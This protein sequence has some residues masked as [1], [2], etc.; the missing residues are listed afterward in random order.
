M[1]WPVS[2]TTGRGADRCYLAWD[3]GVELPPGVPAASWA[4]RS[5]T[6][7]LS[8]SLRRSFAADGWLES[9]STSAGA[10]V[11]A[12]WGRPR[13]S[14][15]SGPRL[16]PQCRRSAGRRPDRYALMSA[17]TCQSETECSS[18]GAG[19][20]SS[21]WVLEPVPHPSRAVL[22]TGGVVRSL[23]V[24][25]A[26]APSRF[27]FFPPPRKRSGGRCRVPPTGSP[28]GLRRAGPSAAAARDFPVPPARARPLWW[29]RG[30]TGPALVA[31]WSSVAPLHFGKIKSGLGLRPPEQGTPRPRPRR[32]LGGSECLRPDR[33][34][35]C[36]EIDTPWRL[37][38]P[39]QKYPGPRGS[40]PCAP[41]RRAPPPRGVRQAGTPPAGPNGARGP[42]AAQPVVPGRGK[43]AP[44]ACAPGGD[45]ARP[46]QTGRPSPPRAGGGGMTV[47]SWAQLPVHVPRPFFQAVLALRPDALSRRQ[48]AR[49]AMRPDPGLEKWP[50]SSGRSRRCAQTCPTPGGRASLVPWAGPGGRCMLAPRPAGT[51]IA[52]PATW[53]AMAMP[54]PHCRPALAH[55]RCRRGRPRAARIASA[56]GNCVLYLFRSPTTAHRRCAGPAALLHLVGKPSMFLRPRRVRGKVQASHGVPCPSMAAA[57][58]AVANSPVRPAMSSTGMPE[59]RQPPG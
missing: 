36:T 57:P 9:S 42:P 23:L 49:S 54:P 10:C 7:V 24:T 8:I 51:P 18:C 11:T 58:P 29:R 14:I 6:R 41:G 45:P 30:R 35:P 50:L 22:T 59:A 33:S 53:F 39:F 5:R 15:R 34:L 37:A 38:S 2:V 13:T 55:C 20:G 46:P 52:L 40:I 44:L 43:C 3:I 28:C 31:R 27:R 19:E 16:W 25:V 21:R 12:P 1:D 56:S 48:L 26:P 4:T 17:P 47:K 32:A